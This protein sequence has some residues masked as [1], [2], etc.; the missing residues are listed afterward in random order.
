M[1]KEQLEKKVKWLDDERRKD[2][3]TITDLQKKIETLEGLIEKSAEH[4]KGLSGEV[5]RSKVML[6]KFD[7]YDKAIVSHRQEVKK[8]LD[9]QEKLAKRRETEFKKSQKLD[10]V[11]SEKAIA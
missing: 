2:K 11:D 1:D 9:N 10:L 3:G 5:T 8:E 7:E 6:E 4:I